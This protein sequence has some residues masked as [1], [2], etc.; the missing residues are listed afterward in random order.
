MFSWYSSASTSQTL[1]TDWRINTYI[2]NVTVSLLLWIWT[3]GSSSGSV[4]PPKNAISSRV[5]LTKCSL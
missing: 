1:Q 5:Q 3:A 4:P 2:T